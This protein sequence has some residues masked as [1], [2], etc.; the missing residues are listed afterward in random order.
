MEII[1]IIKALS[2]QDYK[3]AR[4]QGGDY[5]FLCKT[6]EEEVSTIVI[7]DD[8]R[9][10]KLADAEQCTTIAKAFEN[11]FLLRGYKQVNTLFLILTDKPYDFK[12]FSEGEFV[13]WVG[14]I[15][16]ERLLSFIEN[17]TAFDSIRQSVESA[18]S[19]PDKK[20]FSIKNRSLRSFLS[21]PLITVILLLLN[22]LIFLYMDIFASL[23]EKAL[24]LLNYAN[25]STVTFEQ[26]EFY[27]LI[28]CTFLHADISHLLGN[29]LSLFVVGIQLESVIGHIKLTA[30]YLI[31]GLGASICSLLYYNKIEVISIA[32]GASGAV[33]GLI[34]AYI[35]LILL[36]R[37]DRRDV[38][39]SRI[40]FA[41]AIML[42]SGIQQGSI[43]NAA[44]F[45]GII[46]GSIIAYI[47]CICSKNKI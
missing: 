19:T 18:L 28:T 32:I 38:S 3:I 26:N 5:T 13:Y 21:K 43:D 14:D 17:D 8:I 2:E 16:S 42:Y 27:R 7:I 25:I 45:G 34:G 15:Y 1:N 37:I 10:P 40:F 41:V 30:L 12:T 36:G 4:L 9:Y 31:S 24:L 29:M 39:I 11:T 47:Y 20:S 33:F 46:I 6:N 23:E 22:I 35:T 44:H